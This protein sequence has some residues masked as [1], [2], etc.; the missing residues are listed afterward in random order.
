[1]NRSSD[2]SGAP[3][4]P[5]TPGYHYEPGALV[6]LEQAADRLALDRERLRECCEV[7]AERCG[8]IA[9]AHLEAGVVAIESGGRW[10][11]RLPFRFPLPSPR[12][13]RGTR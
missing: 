9:V 13:P 3:P 1:M 10:R 11:F 7:A 8:D 6:S 2:R 12:A 4:R 5:A